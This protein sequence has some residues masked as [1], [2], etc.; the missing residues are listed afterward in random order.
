MFN[1]TKRVSFTVVIA[2]LLGWGVMS[3]LILRSA[4]YSLQADTL[5][6]GSTAIRSPNVKL[7]M[8]VDKRV[9]R[10]GE[11]VLISLRN[12]SRT[13]IW[14][15]TTASGCVTSWWTVERLEDGDFWRPVGLTKA[16]CSIPI[17][18]NQFAKHDLRTAEW[19]SLVPGPQLGEV[20]I[21]AP[22]GTYHIA[23][24]YLKGKQVAEI[25]WQQ[26]ELPK[27]TSPSFT[28]Q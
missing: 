19:N 25:N 17:G 26:A 10:A 11:T 24:P 8:Q 5:D 28:I 18:I 22:T 27:I 12:D 16:A 13:P 3:L 9:Y 7:T 2:L 15:P 1:A 21:N 23:T 20:Y 14:L 4:D 6:A